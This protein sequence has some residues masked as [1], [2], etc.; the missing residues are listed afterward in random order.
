MAFETIEKIGANEYTVTL[1]IDAE[2]F[3]KSVNTVFNK[4]KGKIAIPGFRK[5]KAPR[6]FIEKYY[7]ENVFYDDALEDAFPSIYKEALDASELKAVDSPKDFDIKTIGKD[8]VELTCVVTVKPEIVLSQYKGLSAEKK[9]VSVSDEEVEHEL[10]HMQQ[11]NARRIDI[12]DRPVQDKDIVTI[13]YDGSVDGVPFAGGKS[14]NYALTIGSGQFIPGFE[15][16]LISHNIGEEFDINV[17]FPEEYAEELA[18]KDAVFKIK[19]HAIQFDELPELDDDFAKDVSE[20]DTIEELKASVKNDILKKKEADSSK[21]FENALLE[22]LAENVEAEIPDCMIEKAIDNIVSDF[23]YR[24]RSQ[25]LT[26]DTYLQYL[27]MDMEDF[28][29]QHE[30]TATANVEVELALEKI[31]E[32]ENFEISEA[33]IEAEYETFAERYKMELDKVKE[34]IA[35]DNVKKDLSTRKALDL[36]VSS[37][38]ALKSEENADSEE[39]ATKEKPKTVKAKA[40]KAEKTDSEEN[41][42]EEKPKA[43]RATKKAE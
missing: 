11:H 6:K 27:G 28:R 39:K 17:T 13:D 5:G 36:I 14:E 18:G 21:A 32:T 41:A 37:A 22:K 30:E 9:E 3:E 7:G 26:L 23:D 40:V 2:T 35:I 16:Q 42:E 12:D 10:E 19:I 1:K 38:I 8:G 25:G 34:I 29:A 33:E 24:M 4:Q 15:E 20:V 31:I 43:K